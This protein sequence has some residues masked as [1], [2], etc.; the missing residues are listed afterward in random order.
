M[1]DADVEIA[2]R[3]IHANLV[4]LRR[5]GIQRALVD[6]ATQGKV[7]T[8][9]WKKL[10]NRIEWL[11]GTITHRKLMWPD[12]KATIAA[13]LLTTDRTDYLRMRRPA[14]ET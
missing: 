12:I 3:E 14:A 1:S 8:Y 7:I 2:F 11:D 6:L 10:A 5:H 13:Q 4:I 9:A